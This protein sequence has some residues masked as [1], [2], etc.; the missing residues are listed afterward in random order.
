MLRLTVAQLRSSGSRL[1][2]AGV[3][4]V[5]GTAFIAA[6]LLG[7]SLLREVTHRAVTASLGGADVVVYPMSS[8][9]DD[10]ALTT[11]GEVS[12]VAA[13]SGSRQLT[14]SVSHDGHQSMT[15]IEPT[16]PGEL[17]VYDLLEG[18]T[19][20]PGEVAI[21]EASSER[22]NVGLGDELE[23]SLAPQSPEG[24]DEES[25]TGSEQAAAG[26][27]LTVTGV[28]ANPPALVSQG[29]VSLMAPEELATWADASGAGGDYDMLLAT[30]GAGYGQEELAEEVSAAL[31]DAQVRTGDDVAAEQT[32]S[33]TG[34]RY[35]FTALVFGA[36][37][38]AMFVAAIVITN[39]F[40]VVVAQRTRHL[41]LLRCVGATRGQV[42]RSVLIEAF[43]LGLVAS[44]VGLA[45]GAG[46]AQ[47]VLWLLPGQE[48]GLPLPA[49]V[50]MTPDVVLA[51]LLIGVVVTV[52]AALPPAR[53]ATRVLPVAAL[54]PPRPVRNKGG[55]WPRALVSLLLLSA[56]IAMLAAGPLRALR[57]EVEETAA[58]QSGLLLG[59][60]GGVVSFAGLMLGAIFFIP[61]LVRLI[62]GIVRRCGGGATAQLATANAVRNPARTSATATA[63]LI[64]VTLVSL[65]ATGAA[66]ARASLDQLVDAQFPVD[67]IAEASPALPPE[68]ATLSPPQREIIEDTEGVL[69]TT[70]VT[71]VATTL[72]TGEDE[73]S[74]AATINGL[75][76]TEARGVIHDERSLDGLVPGAIVVPTDEAEQLG[77]STGE[78]VA[79][80]QPG[81]Q[82]R[83]EAIVSEHT[84]EVLVTD[85]D[86]A[87]LAP[88]VDDNAMWVQLRSSDQAGVITDIKDRLAAAGPGASAQT[89][90]QVFVH[91]PAAERQMYEQIIDALLLIIIGLLG[92][93]VVI[94]LIGVANTLSLSVIE[95]QRESAT[96]RALGLTRGQLR[97]MLA[98]E[99]ALLALIGTGLGGVLGVGYGFAGSTILLGRTGELALQVPWGALGLVV[100]VALL[101]GLAA[102]VLPARRAV[103]TPP[104][105]ALGTE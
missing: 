103:H 71:Q 80:G 67:M 55:S 97:G 4:I 69:A 94:A 24:S 1:L 19:P 42:R 66:S 73:D 35:I 84:G 32:A 9:L 12:G 13:A 68:E 26:E 79:L 54:Q 81:S 100:A 30:A 38:I 23:V 65:M 16:R 59:V 49:R 78:E 95:R 83:L 88:E 15:T 40:Q 64:G 58:M 6:A 18:S 34:S 56:G 60:A 29:E 43:G 3:A 52:L 25:A 70:S 20:Q 51:P 86:A 47:L 98:V 44:F 74:V 14:G 75:D 101:A 36:A 105:A 96:L 85:T 17:S 77:L 91:G 8:A 41:A 5:V 87:R 92:V 76:V 62:G 45:T 28:L 50:D 104:V 53:A 57:E 46:M 90:S 72:M 7:S 37:A 99:G 27:E 48:W 33:V 61:P 93:A 22:L 21:T 63:L 89:D 31:D 82:Q 102:S 39:T 10:S 11:L 2:A